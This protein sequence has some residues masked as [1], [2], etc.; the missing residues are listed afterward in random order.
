MELK[1]YK[2]SISKATGITDN[3][4]LSRIE[5]SMRDDIFHST[6]DWQTSR[7]FNKGA[8]EALELI[9]HMDSPEGIAEL[10]A[11]RAQYA[12]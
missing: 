2:L 1:G 10:E 12:A 3:A 9:R 11:I 6:L 8:R 5:E 4:L 7:Q